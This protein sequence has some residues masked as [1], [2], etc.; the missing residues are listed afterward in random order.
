MFQAPASAEP[1]LGAQPP[2]ADHKAKTALAFVRRSAGGGGL[3][4]GRM[5]PP[6]PTGARGQR[7]PSCCGEQS[8]PESGHNGAVHV[9]PLWKHEAFSS[10]ATVTFSPYYQLAVT[11]EIASTGGDMAG[12]PRSDDR[13]ATVTRHNSRGFEEQLDTQV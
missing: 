12:R 13:R 11:T 3:R 2:A 5:S 10:L 1:T 9:L 7:P 8:G 6:A 4:K